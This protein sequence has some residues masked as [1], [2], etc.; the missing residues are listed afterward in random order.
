MGPLKP[1]VTV[2]EIYSYT[3]TIDLNEVFK[4]GEAKWKWLTW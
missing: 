3:N 1:S 4:S 2:N